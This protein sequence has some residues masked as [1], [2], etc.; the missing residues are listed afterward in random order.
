VVATIT[1]DKNRT[2]MQWA[3]APNAGFS[4]AGVATWLPVNPN[5][6][7]V[8]NVAE[9]RDDPDSLWHFY[10]DLLR[11]RKDTPALVAGDYQVVRSEAEAYFAFI[12]STEAQRCLVVLNYVDQEL[13]MTIDLDTP[14]GKLVFSSRRRDD[15][16]D[17]ES[18]DLAPYEVLVVELE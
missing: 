10:Q 1:R 12:R 13:F 3:N 17:L 15:V 6:A 7:E 8:I 9:Q 18:L 4:P 14:K 11:V 2:P 16:I 5:Y